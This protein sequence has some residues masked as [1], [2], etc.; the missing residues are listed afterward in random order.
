MST[1]RRFLQAGA[2]V[3]A[4]VVADRVFGQQRPLARYAKIDLHTH[5]GTAQGEIFKLKRDGIP[6]ACD[7]LLRR[8]AEY[9]VEKAVLVPV[10]PIMQTTHYEEAHRL[11]PNRLL[12][13]ASTTVRPLNTQLEWLKKWRDLGAVALKMN[14]LTYDPKDEAAERI[15][16]EAVKLGMPVFFHHQNFPPDV[17]QIIYHLATQHPEG[18]F[19]VIH[20]GGTFG[21]QQVLPLAAGLPNVYLETSSAFSHIVRSPMRSQ[22]DYFNRLGRDRSGF[23]KVMFGSEFVDS[24]GDVLGAIEEMKL[25]AKV[26]EEVL[27]GNAR[28]ILKL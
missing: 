27:S 14:P 20:F 24:Y 25:E 21:F 9:G 12:F 4:S 2:G 13:A 18:T 16:F 15:I 1:R 10:E 11:H 23:S 22:L 28:K 8:M 17:P 3:A 19:V 7:Y 26:M 6:A 5:L